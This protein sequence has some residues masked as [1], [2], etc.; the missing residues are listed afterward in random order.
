[1]A[2]YAYVKDGIVTNVIVGRDEDDIPADFD[3]NTWEDYFSSLGDGVSIRT[4]YNTWGGVHYNP[5]TGKPSD[6]QTRALRYNYAGIG[7][8]YDEVRDAF[9]PPQPYPSWTMSEDTCLWVAPVLM[10]TDEKKY[11]WDESTLSWVSNDAV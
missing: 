11:Q 3:F 2:H 4:S 7:F 6:D 10:P 8:T 5:E 1:M 9:I